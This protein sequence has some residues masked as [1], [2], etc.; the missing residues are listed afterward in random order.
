MLVVTISDNGLF[1]AGYLSTN[2]MFYRHLCYN[3]RNG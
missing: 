2:Y 1:E 3:T